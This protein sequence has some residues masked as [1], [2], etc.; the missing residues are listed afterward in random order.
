M[1]RTL[2]LPPCLFFFWTEFLEGKVSR[3]EATERILRDLPASR[4]ADRRL[5]I[6]DCYCSLG[7][8]D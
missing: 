3:A 7:I 4:I 6:V 1:R 2:H 8:A 5:R